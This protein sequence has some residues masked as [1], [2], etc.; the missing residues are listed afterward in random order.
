MTTDS[1]RRKLDGSIAGYKGCGIV[2]G[3]IE[4]PG[5]F[6]SSFHQLRIRDRIETADSV[7]RL[8]WRADERVML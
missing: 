8:C 1:E 5:F 7:E 4:T 2:T 6:P 3:M